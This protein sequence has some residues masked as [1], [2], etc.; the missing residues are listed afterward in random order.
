ML[1]A[2]LVHN[3]SHHAGKQFPPDGGE[4]FF[5]RVP[6]FHSYG[7][8]DRFSDPV[9]TD[10]RPARISDDARAVESWR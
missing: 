7:L 8:I 4:E 5:V 1:Q 10:P 3:I 6:G 9:I 2:D